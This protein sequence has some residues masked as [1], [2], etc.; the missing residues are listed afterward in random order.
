M[1]IS[2]EN[3]FFCL[4]LSGRLRQ[5]WLYALTVEGNMSL[6]LR[7]PD[8]CICENKAADQFCGLISGFVFATWIVQSLYFLNPKF[9]ASC[10]PLWWHSLV[11]VGPGR[12]P[13]RPVFIA[14]AYSKVRY[15]GST[16]RPFVRSCVRSSVRLSVRPSVHNSCQ[17]AYSV[18]VIAGSMKPCIVT[19]LDTLFKQAPWPS[20]LDL[21]FTLHWLCQN[22]ASSLENL[23]RV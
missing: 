12:K 2:L 3:P 6:A 17:G 10:H 20:A 21:D 15:R 4:L 16:F 8:F 13:Q 11:C 19:T 23:C 18:A 7:K 22:F 5:V 1:I 9:L 14:P